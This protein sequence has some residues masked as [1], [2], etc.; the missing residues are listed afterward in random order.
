MW[1]HLR[2][3]GNIQ[4]EAGLAGRVQV[5]FTHVWWLGELDERLSSEGTVPWSARVWF[6]YHGDLRILGLF[7]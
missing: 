6:F 1:H 3:P 4:L 5:S 7:T 2:S